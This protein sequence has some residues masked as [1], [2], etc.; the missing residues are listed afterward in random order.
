MWYV[1]PPVYVICM[2]LF[3]DVVFT[4]PVT[5]VQ[6]MG[7]TSFEMLPLEAVAS[8]SNISALGN[9][10]VRRQVADGPHFL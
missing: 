5:L 3:G 2:H 6:G 10:S 4:F 9:I 7:V 1:V 8:C